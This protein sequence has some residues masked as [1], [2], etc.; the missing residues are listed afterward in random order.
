MREGKDWKAI[1]KSN[2]FEVPQSK[3][4]KVTIYNNYGN[5]ER[6]YTVDLWEAFHLQTWTNEQ[7]IL[8]PRALLALPFP[9]PTPMLVFL[10]FV[11]VQVGVV[12][13]V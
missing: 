12:L 8:K 11:K 7:W 1:V 6:Y 13:K 4:Q 9:D 5:K 10:L 2:F 3:W